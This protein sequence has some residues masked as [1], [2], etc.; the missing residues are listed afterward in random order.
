MQNM[1]QLLTGEPDINVKETA[2]GT[3]QATP[4][5]AVGV[6]PVFLTNT[7]RVMNVLEY[8]QW[9]ENA[10]SKA[11]RLA[12]EAANIFNYNMFNDNLEYYAEQAMKDPVFLNAT[13]ED[14]RKMWST[15]VDN[16]RKAT[17]LR[18]EMNSFAAGDTF[19]QQNELVTKYTE[20]Q[21]SEAMDDLE[22]GDNIGSLDYEQITSLQNYL[23]GIKLVEEES[24]TLNRPWATR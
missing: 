13:L 21:L 14:Q 12:A 3:A 16:A 9:K 18:M 24:E 8:D 1:T 15:A 10:S 22:L 23:K 20:D 2:V 7:M 11:T 6:R 5:A 17:K 4:A 19:Y